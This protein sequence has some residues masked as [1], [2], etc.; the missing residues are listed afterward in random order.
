MYIS[1]KLELLSLPSSSSTEVALEFGGT[2]SEGSSEGR[3]LYRDFIRGGISVDA[4]VS[5]PSSSNIASTSV[6]IMGGQ[7]TSKYDRGIEILS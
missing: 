3:M 1:E 4:R 5:I 7:S 2:N 6:A